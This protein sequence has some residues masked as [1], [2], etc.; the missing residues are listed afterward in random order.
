MINRNDSYVQWTK[1]DHPDGTRLRF[2]GK[3]LSAEFHQ[4]VI[5]LARE[6]L[7]GESILRSLKQSGEMN[8]EMKD[9]LPTNGSIISTFLRNRR[10]YND[11]GTVLPQ[12]TNMLDVLRLASRRHVSNAEELEAIE[13]EYQVIVLQVRNLIHPMCV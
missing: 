13:D 8:K 12:I 4:T 9:R 10:R 6:D 5:R 2:E 3:G 1:G 7:G 11:D